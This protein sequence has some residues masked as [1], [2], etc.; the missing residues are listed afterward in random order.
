M[1][2]KPYFDQVAEQW[3]TLRQ[4]FFS[5]AIRDQALHAAGVRPGQLAADVG[6][7]SGFITEGLVAL[8]AHVIAV[9]ESEAML[10]ALQRRLPD[11]EGVEVRV[12]EAEAL[13]IED[14]SVDCAFANMVL[15]HVEHPAAALAEMARILKP[16]GVLVVT[17][18]DERNFEFL[19]TE[20]HDRWLGFRRADVRAWLEAA[21][22][23]AP[24]VIGTQNNCCADS[25]C[26]TQRADV[27]VFLAMGRKPGGA[28]P[29]EGVD[30]HSA[31]RQH[32]G[33][34]A[35]ASDPELAVVSAP[36]CCGDAAP[37]ASCC[38][39][40][41]YDPAL[42]AD[43]PASVTGLSLGCGDPVTLAGLQPGEV[44]LDLGSGAGID[45][46]LAAR[47]VG[48]TG[49][50]IGVDMTPDMLEKAN[51]NKARLGATNVE[52]RQGQIEAL[53]VAD[54]SVNVVMSNCVIN[55]S[56]DKA[57][58]FREA[59]RV[60]KPGGRVSISDIVTEGFGAEG[61][62]F[63]AR[64]W[65]E[66][67]AGAIDVNEYMDLM[68]AAGFVDV[69]AVDKAEDASAVADGGPRVY[70]ARITGRKPA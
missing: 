30:I 52:F 22:L 37:A 27:S 38:A 41:L 48:E 65:S 39:P 3:D 14:A 24:M 17:D 21:G 42:L 6:A 13:P 7:G 31:V 66:C 25:A 63:D 1:S 64:L 19:R 40:A 8:G 2:S 53:P 49:A 23:E 45:C 34:I 44:V 28:A 70:S 5:E 15:H 50:V 61:L 9:D 57:Q 43:L 36:S 16:G 69:Q 33:A 32:Y 4:G 59:Y 55:L 18:L 58:V 11:A 26:G 46:F 54:N 47:Q 62:P 60:L 20:H 10:A 67:V 12:G 51:A 68:R 35:R 29:A 56:P